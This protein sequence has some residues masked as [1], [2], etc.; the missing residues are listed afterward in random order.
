VKFADQFTLPLS[1]DQVM[2]AVQS[3]VKTLGW[4]TLE[5]GV[6]R[7]LCREPLALVLTSPVTV[8]LLLV[9]QPTGTR[10][11]INVSS[12]GIGPIQAKHQR[13][14]AAIL[15]QQIRQ[16]V[17]QASGQVSTAPTEILTGNIFVSYRR[18]DS[19]DATGRIYDRLVAHFGREKVFKDVDDIPIGVD[20]RKHIEDVVDRCLVLLAVIGDQ[21][22]TIRD[23]LGNRRLDDPNDFVRIEIE[24]ALKHDIPVVPLLVRGAVMPTENDLPD[25]LKPLVY[26]NGVIIRRDPDFDGD[27]HRLIKGLD[28]YFK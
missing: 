9:K 21:W 17:G 6:D 1:L 14:Q 25:T 15:Q 26:R 12:I 27:I 16:A 24:R 11:A 19:A 22:A 18:D 13:T 3:A 2:D 8:E 7:L 20:F 5:I 4:E 10:V 23:K 28:Q